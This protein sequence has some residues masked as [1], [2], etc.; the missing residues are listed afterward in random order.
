MHTQ[1]SGTCTFVTGSV[2]AASHAHA[3][4]EEVEAITLGRTGDHRAFAWIVDRYKHMVHTTCFR[5]L[6]NQ[7]GSE[8]A[9]QDTFVKAYQNIG[10][11]QGGSKF[12][13]W[14]FSIAYRTAI[15]QLR[16]RRVGS[17]S[18]DDL[19]AADEPS[20]EASGMTETGD[21]TTALNKALAKLP[22]EDAAIVSFFYLDEMSVEEIVTV[23]G[24]GASNVKVKLHRS[25]KRLLEILQDDLKEEA[26]TLVED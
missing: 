12:S 8:E 13:T 6:R 5:I 23:T 7:E 18:I 22:A 17:S 10:S 24:L 21:R 15:S 19:A 26:W 9:T 3:N 1:L 14:L 2:H 20:Q 11:Y 25:R 4:V 16:K